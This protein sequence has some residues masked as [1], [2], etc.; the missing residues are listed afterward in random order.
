MNGQ[1]QFPPL[2]LLKV[3]KDGDGK[4]MIYDRR[5]DGKVIKEI[6]VVPSFV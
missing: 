2:T 6:H 5:E 4:F 1:C 3:M